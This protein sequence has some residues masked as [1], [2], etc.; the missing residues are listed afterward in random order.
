MD[1]SQDMMAYVCPMHASSLCRH[2]VITRVLCV[3][4]PTKSNL[5]YVVFFLF[6]FS[7]F[8]DK[9]NVCILKA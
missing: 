2:I 7:L 9:W 6:D 4:E 1:A 3:L 8:H 5:V